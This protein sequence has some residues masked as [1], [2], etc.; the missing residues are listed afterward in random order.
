[1]TPGSQHFTAEGV[2]TFPGG[3]SLRRRRRPA[4]MLNPVPLAQ[5][6]MLEGLVIPLLGKT[7][8]IALFHFVFCDLS[9]FDHDGSH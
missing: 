1:M 8:V 3:A 7:L 6:Y 2:R 9:S 4:S 5:A